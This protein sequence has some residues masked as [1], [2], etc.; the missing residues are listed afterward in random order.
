MLK[1]RPRSDSCSLKARAINLGPVHPQAMDHV[2]MYELLSNRPCRGRIC[3]PVRT[4][5][6]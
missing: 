4:H 2:P 1:G 3:L 6:G 5:R